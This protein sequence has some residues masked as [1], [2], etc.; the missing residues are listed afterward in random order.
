MFKWTDEEEEHQF[1]QKFIYF[2]ALNVSL[3]LNNYDGKSDIF[4]NS[5][6]IGRK[7]LFSILFK[8][9]K[10]QRLGIEQ[11][12]HITTSEWSLVPNGRKGKFSIDSQVYPVEAVEAK[13][14]KN[15]GT[16]YCL[17]QQTD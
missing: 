14:L 10:G 15:Y 8:Q 17:S 4:V 6:D 5:G 11:L 2:D 12:T 3:D 7:G 9:R 16:I 1:S 13:V